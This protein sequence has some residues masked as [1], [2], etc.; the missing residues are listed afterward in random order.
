MGKKSVY[1]AL[2]M[3]VLVSFSVSAAYDWQNTL[4][5]VISKINDF[6]SS[7]YSNYPKAYDFVLFFVIFTSIAMIGFGKVFTGNWGSTGT[8]GAMKALA[9]AVGLSLT[10]A[11]M[12]NP[13]YPMSL[14]TFL[15][16]FAKNIIFFLFFI[17]LIGLY[18]YMGVQNWFWA[19]LLAAFTTYLL[20]A[21]ITADPSAGLPS[22]C[23][24]TG[25]GGDVEWLTQATG[26]KQY[27]E[28]VIKYADDN[29]VEACLLYALIRQESGW[30]PLST[31]ST[32]AAGLA[33][34]T[35]TDAEGNGLT[36][37]HCYGQDKAGVV[38]ECYER[39]NRVGQRVEYTKDQRYDP[40]TSIR[41]GAKHLKG[42][43]S[44]FDSALTDQKWFGIAAY[45]AGQRPIIA[46]ITSLKNQGNSDSKWEDVVR[47]LTPDFLRDNGYTDEWVRTNV[48]AVIAGTQS[49]QDYRT[50]KVTEITMHVQKVRGHYDD[51]VKSSKVST[52]TTVDLSKPAADGT[53]KLGTETA[54]GKETTPTSAPLKPGEIRIVRKQPTGDSII[55]P[56]GKFEVIIDIQTDL[57]IGNM[58][59]HWY[60]YKNDQKTEVASLT[61]PQ[62]KMTKKENI[63]KEFDVSSLD[64]GGYFIKLNVAPSASAKS[65][66][67]VTTFWGVTVE[68]DAARRDEI[69]AERERKLAD[70]NEKAKVVLAEIKHAR[71]DS[72]LSDTGRQLKIIEF[73]KRLDALQKEKDALSVSTTATTK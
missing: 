43:L 29:G 55:V 61:E 4:K 39:P 36:V 15:Y 62:Q 50:Q 23:E 19:A 25:A 46:A 30:N 59:Y 24:R 70:I 41:I 68:R 6:A 63:R 9:V 13:K 51:C 26:N 16:P 3:L 10:F 14:S 45:N 73:Y 33:Q 60:F 37:Y 7:T 27:A 18:K 54:G 58:V 47:I 42:K 32:G 17:I 53:T 38:P 49:I 12:F 2:I 35:Y 1:I 28:W 21:I 11:A 52:P 67:V 44:N 64:D 56:P 57:P 40:E 34:L 48:R 69:K 31:S 65:S 66:E 20:F 5:D 71:E 22:G 8:T 72:S